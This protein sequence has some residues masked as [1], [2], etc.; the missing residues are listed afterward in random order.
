V[1]LR[2]TK[3]GT[4]IGQHPRQSDAMLVVERQHPIVEVSTPERKRIGFGEP[5]PL[6]RGQ[7]RP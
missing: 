4:A 3:F 1:A 6:C 5:V 7:S 2:P